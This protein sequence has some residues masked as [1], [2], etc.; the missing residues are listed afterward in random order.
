MVTMLRRCL[1]RINVAVSSLGEP[2]ITPRDILN[3]TKTYTI[4]V[5]ARA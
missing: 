1:P 5:S 4:T 2:G 3:S